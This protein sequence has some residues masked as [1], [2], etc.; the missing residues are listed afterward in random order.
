MGSGKLT[1]S[2]ARDQA[3]AADCVAEW[4]AS[5]L[6]EFFSFESYDPLP[7]RLTGAFLRVS[8]RRTDQSPQDVLLCWSDAG[9]TI[10]RPEPT[11]N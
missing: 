10:I 6:S 9:G 4:P 8:A 1:V 5:L 7:H 3:A 2:G 11:K